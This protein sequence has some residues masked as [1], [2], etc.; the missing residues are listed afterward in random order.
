MGYWASD[1]A[2]TADVVNYMY[3]DSPNTTSAITYAVSFAN[4]TSCTISYLNRTVNDVDGAGY[5]R[6]VSILI[7][8]EIGG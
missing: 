1:S 7:A 3:Y 4:P 2:S 6:G 5:E 8:Q